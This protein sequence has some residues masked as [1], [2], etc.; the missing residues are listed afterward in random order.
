MAFAGLSPDEASNTVRRFFRCA[1]VASAQPRIPWRER[2]VEQFFSEAFCRSSPTATKS[3]GTG[4][5]RAREF[6]TEF[7]WE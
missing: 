1:F 3:C 5:I 6:F 4:F 2:K 7:V